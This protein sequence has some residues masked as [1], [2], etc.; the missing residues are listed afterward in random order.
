MKV[1]V[2]RM[3]AVSLAGAAAAAL[4]ACASPA[5]ARPAAVHSPRPRATEAATTDPATANERA[6]A[7]GMAQ[8]I[9]SVP[10][11]SVA[12]PAPSGQDHMRMASTRRWS[13]G[14]KL[15]VDRCSPVL[16][17]VRVL[18]LWQDA[19]DARSSH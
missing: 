13:E 10:A 4:A 8:S 19:R 3:L 5:P 6:F 15:T 12:G 18:D 14:L 16:D 7:A 1:T 17:L 11:A 9:V 2:R